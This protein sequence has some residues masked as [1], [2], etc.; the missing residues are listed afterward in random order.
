MGCE[1]EGAA[2]ASKTK[3][4]Y[5]YGEIH[6]RDLPVLLLGVVRRIPTG[7]FS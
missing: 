1:C 5:L 2:A 7:T 4:D 6:Y 3:L